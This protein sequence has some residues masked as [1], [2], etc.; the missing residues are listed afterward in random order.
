MKVCL[1]W[2]FIQH[3]MHEDKTHVVEKCLWDKTDQ[4]CIQ[5]EC[6]TIST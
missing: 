4:N 6:D 1:I 3:S 5:M 2:K